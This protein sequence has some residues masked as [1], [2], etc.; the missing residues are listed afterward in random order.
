MQILVRSAYKQ[1]GIENIKV[2]KVFESHVKNPECINT[3]TLLS[4]D[5][6]GNRKLGK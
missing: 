1:V 5:N 3:N 6:M 2:F 4:D